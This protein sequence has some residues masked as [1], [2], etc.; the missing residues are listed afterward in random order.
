MY[1]QN[2]DAGRPYCYLVE[3]LNPHARYF[4]VI[5]AMLLVLKPDPRMLANWAPLGPNLW[6]VPRPQRATGD[7]NLVVVTT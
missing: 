2:R 6:L 5:E 4:M 7:F 3:A 1:R